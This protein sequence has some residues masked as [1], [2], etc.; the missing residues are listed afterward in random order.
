MTIRT[1]RITATGQRIELA[2]HDVTEDQPATP[3][4]GQWPKCRCRRCARRQ[5]DQVDGIPA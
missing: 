5:V 2:Q 4:T 3:I 1:Y